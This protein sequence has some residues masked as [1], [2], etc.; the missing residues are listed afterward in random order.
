LDWAVAFYQIIFHAAGGGLLM[1]RSFRQ[2][3][4]WLTIG[5][6]GVLCLV[7]IYEFGEWA[8]RR[9]IQALTQANQRT[10]EVQ[11]LALRGTV[12]RYQ[13]VPFTIARNVDMVQL[14]QK[15]TDRARLSRVNDY[16]QEVNR[17]VGA[18]ALYLMDANGR[19][20]AASNWNAAISFVGDDYSFRPYFKEAR[21]GSHG[22][23]YAVGSATRVPGLFLSAPVMADGQVM[24]VIAIKVSL[25]EIEEAW[26][27]GGDPVVLLDARGIVFLG[28]DPSW[29][30]LATQ[31]LNL[32]DMQWLTQHLPYGKQ[33]NFSKRRLP[34]SNPIQ[35]P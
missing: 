27:N 13:D 3:A 33:A 20:L 19:T 24:G 8:S 10:L 1:L 9:E 16:L 29:L 17:R 2:F 32:H 14:L 18:D 34:H 11:K 7:L 12:N 6:Y 25:R 21:S 15:P 31:V 26:R 23:Y 4:R 30:Y 35:R 5:F 28:A 22:F